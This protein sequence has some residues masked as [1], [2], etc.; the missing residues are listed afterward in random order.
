LIDKK[1]R[2]MKIYFYLLI[3]LFTTF[4]FG[5][6]VVEAEYFWDVDPGQGNGTILV[7]LDN[8]FNQALETVVTNNANLP[9]EGM[10]TLGI[11]IKGVD[12]NWSP[13]YRKIIKTENSSFSN[14]QFKLTQAEYYW[15]NNPGFGNA[16]PMIAFDGNF[17][18]AIESLLQN[19]ALLPQE[20]NH[21]LAIRVKGSDGNWSPDFKKIIKISF[22]TNTNGTSKI[23]TG[24]YFWD[25][26]MTNG[27]TLLAFDGDFNQALETIFNTTTNLPSSG[28]H[29]I[30]LRIKSEDETWSPIYSRIIAINVT[31]NESVLL[32]SPVNGSVDVPTNSNFVWSELSGETTYEYQCATNSSF[33][34]IVQ[35][36]LVSDT[37]IPFIDLALNT[38]YYWR[39]RV[40]ENEQVSL[41]SDT[42]SF[43][44]TGTLN[45]TE[46][47]LLNT[48]IVYPNPAKNI[49]N[50]DYNQQ[51]G[52][53]K[54]EIYDATGKNIL[55][56]DLQNKKIDVQNLSEGIYILNLIT[57][58][59]SKLSSQFIKVN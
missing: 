7:A 29:K 43:T 50:I 18:S 22:D 51:I 53:L 38:T 39:V 13:T 9:S 33:T 6:T 56:G 52:D 31:N 15:D 20:G 2:K 26:D 32:I 10:H 45:L 11:R 16:N 3:S 30:S 35:S 57:T 48:I 8:N 34:S 55:K 36:G 58:N 21:V 37:S 59:K 42:W 5:Q 17:N 41:W 1:T 24:E 27:G 54:F 25:D 23:L 19:N 40:N 46:T 44:T 47:E 12:N 49:L 4:S 14:N 28:I